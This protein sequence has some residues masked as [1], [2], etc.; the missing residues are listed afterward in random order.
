MFAK[1]YESCSKST[2]CV[3]PDKHKIL[4]PFCDMCVLFTE[5]KKWS[6]LRKSPFYL[7]PVDDL[8]L[9]ASTATDNPNLDH[10]ETSTLALLGGILPITGGI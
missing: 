9:L 7:C 4:R 6:Y 1:C 2:V 5:Q 3:L 8:A 10:D